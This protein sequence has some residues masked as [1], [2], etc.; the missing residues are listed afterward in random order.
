MVNKSKRKGSRREYQMRDWFKELGLRCKRVIL[1]GALGGKFSGDLDLFLPRQRKPIKVEVKG[2]HF[3]LIESG[4][5]KIKAGVSH[6]AWGKRQVL[7]DAF[8]F[9]GK[10]SGKRLVGVRLRGSQ[11]E[12]GREKVKAVWGA[13]A[14]VEY[15]RGKELATILKFSNIFNS[16]KSIR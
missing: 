14:P 7:R 16:E 6:K 9:T 2:R 11:G 3:N 10:S 12:R 8:I 5:K 4:A 1:S 15:F 13:S